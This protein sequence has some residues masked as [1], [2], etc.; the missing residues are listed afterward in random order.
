MPTKVISGEDCIVN[1]SELFS[2]IGTKAMLV[3]GARSAKM[4]GSQADVITA[5]DKENIQYIVYDKVMSNPTVE[6]AYDGASIAKANNVD[7]IIAIGGGSPID[8]A[9]AMA[10][11]A[12]QDIES[13]ALFSGNYENEVLPLIAIPTTA[14]TGSE[15]TQYSILTDDTA[16]TKRSIATVLIFPIISFLDAKYMMSLPLEITINTSIDAMSHALEGMLSQRASMISDALAKESIR[17]IMDCTALMRKAKSTGSISEFNY[18]FR[19]QLLQASYLAGMVIAQTGTVAVHAMGYSLTYF[20]GIDHGRANGLL[21]AE[22]LRF[23]EK[24]DDVLVAKVLNAM[25]LSS[26]KQCRDLMD[27]LFGEKENIT[28]DEVCEFSKIAMGT[29]NIKNSKVPPKRSGYR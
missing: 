23:V 13:D 11:L 19:D 1:N 17:I 27:E 9:K 4:N 7:F 28:L 29:G 5:L 16:K 22:Y 14:G 24:K 12:V 2:T 10:L 8:A 21:M 20:K 18:E 6:C 3:T 26:I 25:K 15:A